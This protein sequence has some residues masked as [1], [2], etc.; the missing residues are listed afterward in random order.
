MKLK[1]IIIMSFVTILMNWFLI[2]MLNINGSI[3][4][5]TEVMW[6]I[7]FFTGVVFTK[8]IIELFKRLESSD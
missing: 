5:P 7:G 3:I 8:L 4:K 6:I 2:K 1:E